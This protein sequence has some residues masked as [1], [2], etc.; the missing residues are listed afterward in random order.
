M[1][2]TL[3]SLMAALLV[4]GSVACAQPAQDGP[5]GDNARARAQRGERGPR[6]FG[7]GPMMGRGAEMVPLFGEKLENGDFPEG[8]WSFNEE[9]EL[10]ASKDAV[11][12]TK[13][14]YSVR[15][16]SVP[17][18]VSRRLVASETGFPAPVAFWMIF[19][20]SSVGMGLLKIV[21][22]SL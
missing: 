6:G 11:I 14:K 8:V 12:W 22:R 21:S 15:S 17:L 3:S 1:K 18:A 13:E 2:K 20:T 7:F 5:Q 19:F 9:G 10:V 4:C 16:S